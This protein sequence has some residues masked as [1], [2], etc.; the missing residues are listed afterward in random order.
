MLTRAEARRFYDRFVSN[1]VFDLLSGEDIHA[2]LKEAHRVL[3][4]DGYLCASSLTEG[5]TPYNAMVAYGISSEIII[6]RKSRG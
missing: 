3:V 4:P 2:L 1:Y 5:L 6:A